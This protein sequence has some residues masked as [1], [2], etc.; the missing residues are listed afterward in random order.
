[1]LTS[2]TRLGLAARLGYDVNLQD[3]LGLHCVFVT[4]TIPGTPMPYIPSVHT[5]QSL[6]FDGSPRTTV[7][8]VDL[9]VLPNIKASRGSCRFDAF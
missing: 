1:M 8:P 5:H 2:P 7:M 6:P 4:P 9:I 3:G